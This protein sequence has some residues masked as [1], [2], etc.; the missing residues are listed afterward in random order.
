[1]GI[2]PVALLEPLPEPLQAKVRAL[3]PDMELRFPASRDVADLAAAMR[4][5]AYVVTRAVKMPA[6]LLDH[7][8][9]LRLIH[10]WGTGTDGIPLAAARARG[11]PVARSPGVNAATVADL[12]VGLMLAASRQIPQTDAALRRGE[13]DQPAMWDTA[14]DLCESR[15]GLVGFGAIAQAVAARLRGFGCEMCYTR[16]SG[17]DDDTDVAYSELPEL[18]SSCDIVSLHLPLSDATRGMIGAA[19]LA[20]MKPGALLVNTSRGALV[21]EPALIDALQ[22]GPLGAAALDVLAQEP[23]APDNPLLALPNTVVLPHVGGRTRDNLKRMVRH[24]SG[25]I[26]RHAAGEALDPGDMV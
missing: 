19:E 1:M 22:T 23:T 18:L 10:Q 5:A 7:A 20:S 6:A 12:T 14:F 21:D 25:N 4:G 11:I 17:P 2:G 8:P 26:R 13:W 24:W 9:D 16:R 3:T 15:V